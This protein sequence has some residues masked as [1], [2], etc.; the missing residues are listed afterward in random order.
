MTSSE[1]SAV[2]S[3]P[4]LPVSPLGHQSEIRAAGRPWR[5]FPPVFPVGPASKGCWLAGLRKGSRIQDECWRQGLQGAKA[6][7]ARL[8]G[9]EWAG[10]ESCRPSGALAFDGMS[11]P[12][13]RGSRWVQP[14]PSRWDGRDWALPASPVPHPTSRDPAGAYAAANLPGRGH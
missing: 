14:S 5:F 11:W 7:M 12:K 8:D 9:S 4:C 10:L 6:G 3:R 13:A 1:E 2:L